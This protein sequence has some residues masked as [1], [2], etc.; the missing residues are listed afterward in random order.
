[1][2]LSELKE[3]LYSNKVPKNW[4][5]LDEG[6]KP[7]S[8]ILYKNYNVWEF[9]YLDEKGDRHEYQIFKTDTEAFEHLWEKMKEELI[10]FKK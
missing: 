9:F 8:C 4:Y 6:L 10:F 2:D 5:S 1:M 7:D 3:K